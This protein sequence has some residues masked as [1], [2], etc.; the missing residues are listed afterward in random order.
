MGTDTIS[1]SALFVE[2]TTSLLEAGSQVRFRATGSSMHPAIQHADHVTVAPLAGAIA[3]GDVLLCRQ[4]RGPTAHRVVGIRHG[5]TARLILRGDNTDTCDA[6]V[7]SAHVLG[8]VIATRRGTKERR[9]RRRAL[10][11]HVRRSV[12]AV[13]AFAAWA[14]AG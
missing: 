9:V 14:G 5:A 8:R 11:H 7:R 3:R 1:N 13:R 4:G 6:P 12:R 2:L 10:A